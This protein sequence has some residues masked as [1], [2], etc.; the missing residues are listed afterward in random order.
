MTISTSSLSKAAGAAAAV[1]GAIFIGVQ[2]NHPPAFLFAPGAFLHFAFPLPLPPACPALRA[3]A[4]RSSGVSF[5]MRAFA[6]RRPS[7]TAA[8]F[9]RF[10]ISFP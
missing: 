6:P 8:L 7:S 9:L 5:F 1:A 2:I 4:L 10:A 3:I